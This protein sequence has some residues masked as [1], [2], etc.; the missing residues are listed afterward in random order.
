M[1]SIIGGFGVLFGYFIA[2]ILP[3]DTNKAAQKETELWRVI[4]FAFPVFWEILIVLGLI[5]LVKEDS[6]KFLLTKGT[7]EAR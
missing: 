3:P 2:E 5:F 6:I 1:F 7:P 4:Y